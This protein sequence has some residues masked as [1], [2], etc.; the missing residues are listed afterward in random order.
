MKRLGLLFGIAA[1]ALMATTQTAFAQ[2]HEHLNCGHTEA[3]EKLYREHPELRQ[4]EADFPIISKVFWTLRQTEIVPDLPLFHN[5][6]QSIAP[7]PA[8]LDPKP[9]THSSE[10]ADFLS[11]RSR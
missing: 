6:G 5:R 3:Q 4:K 2:Q 10:D 11:F 1:S 8:R 7:P 9:Y